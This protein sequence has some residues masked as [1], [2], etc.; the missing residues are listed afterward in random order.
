[1]LFKLANNNV[2][3]S[4]KDFTIY[5]L[6]LVFGVCVF[7]M[8]NSIEAQQGI[9]K[10]TESQHAAL[11]AL[12]AVINYISVFISVILGFL[13]VYANGF[14]I[15]RRK[16]ELGIYMTLGMDKYHISRVLLYETCSIALVA[17]VSGL[18]LGIILSHLMSIFTAKIF[19]ADMTSFQFI[20]SPAAA[21]KSLLYFGIIFV[22]VIIFNTFS[23]SKYKLI[24]LIY[25][26]RK[27]Q[28]LKIKNITASVVLF[29]LSL[30]FIGTAYYLIIKNGMLDINLMFLA[31]IICGTIGTILFFM[32]LSGF[33]IKVIQKNKKIYFKNLNMFV[34]RQI[35]SK[36]NTNFISMAVVCLV[37]LL[38]IGT[39]STG[40]SLANVLSKTLE[41]SSPF[42]ISIYKS[43][44]DDQKKGSPDLFKDL[45]EKLDLKKYALE[46]S[47]Y[48]V[49]RSGV[50]YRSI[51]DEKLLDSMPDAKYYLD[52]NIEFIK[53]SD[54]NQ[55]AKMQD[56]KALTLAD[57]EY[58]ITSNTSSVK[59]A[60]L[61]IINDKK[62]I[63]V[64][65]KTLIPQDKLI[66][67]SLSTMPYSFEGNFATIIINDHTV[68]SMDIVRTA[69]NLLYKDVNLEKDFVNS[70]K[71]LQKNQTE[72]NAAY[73]F[74]MSKAENY[75][76]TVCTE[77]IVSFLAVYLGFIFLI[78]CAAVL[79]LQQLSEASD[80]KE[81]YGLLK[82]I[83]ADDDMINQALFKQIFIYF[84]MP[85]GLAVVHAYVGLTVVNKIIVMFGKLNIF[86]SILVTGGF[87][88]LIYGSYF[89][90]TYSGSKSIINK[91]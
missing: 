44:I 16:K 22:I 46:V 17:L 29:I 50:Q 36:I 55:I 83:G 9:M 67:I 89:I 20:F 41:G 14:L 40:I 43:Y 91:D 54:Y 23:V 69:V 90:A 68:N 59:N 11:K 21:F 88:I 53:L 84:M 24:D 71:Q 38:T 49:Y 86:H 31:S 8:F 25:G 58:V 34:L 63:R 26:G 32:S 48:G 78:T 4:I 60:L 7:Y 39:F 52:S 74:Y 65:G 73:D 85:L 51:L 76:N 18:G 12:T 75:E 80:N 42:D 33:L 28:T 87:I 19:E 37:L 13:I 6:T 81:R 62:A 35:N 2:K 64:N 27:N 56:K 1:M 30:G 5:F 61:K 10:L 66:E 77:A 3:K 47:H 45:N 79:S 57:N 70:L 15:K 72:E 82:K